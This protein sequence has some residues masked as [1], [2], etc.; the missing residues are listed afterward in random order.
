MNKCTR[1][2]NCRSSIAPEIRSKYDAWDIS[3]VEDIT[4]TKKLPN[5]NNIVN[6]GSVLHESVD[7][8]DIIDYTESQNYDLGHFVKDSH[9]NLGNHAKK[10]EEDANEFNVN[11][12]KQ[13]EFDFKQFMLVNQANNISINS[14]RQFCNALINNDLETKLNHN[15]FIK[16]NDDTQNDDVIEIDKGNCNGLNDP[17]KSPNALKFKE[18]LANDTNFIVIDSD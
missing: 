9:F 15:T 2:I 7:L 5:K 3:S 4:S 12:E 8:D 13:D 6:D 18:D 1:N 16:N 14:S 17:T 10:K 11:E